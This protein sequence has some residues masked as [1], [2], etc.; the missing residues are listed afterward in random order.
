MRQPDINRL[1]RI[2][3]H[4]E[5]IDHIFDSLQAS[6]EKQECEYITIN[7]KSVSLNQLI[8]DMRKDARENREWVVWKLNQI[9]EM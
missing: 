3:E 6:L 8:R 4:Y 2:V 7:H 1:A 5:A 9:K